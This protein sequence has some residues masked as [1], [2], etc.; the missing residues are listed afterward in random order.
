ME[1]LYLQRFAG[2]RNLT[3]LG[4][5][6]GLTCLTASLLQ[7][8]MDTHTQQKA[9]HSITPPGK[10]YFFHPSIASTQISCC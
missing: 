6:A 10:E 1:I 9:A 5:S 3:G 4:P 2:Q 7:Q 8:A